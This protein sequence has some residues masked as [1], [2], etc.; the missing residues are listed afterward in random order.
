MVI[1]DVLAINQQ[2]NATAVTS[3]T[4][5]ATTQPNVVF[6][7]ASHAQKNAAAWFLST[8]KFKSAATFHNTGVKHVAVNVAN[9]TMYQIADTAHESFV[10]LSAHTFQDTIGNTSVVAIHVQHL[11][12]INR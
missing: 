4:N 6:K 9:G 8:T 1:A 11:A 5:H 3:I 2:M 12:A 10:N 7:S